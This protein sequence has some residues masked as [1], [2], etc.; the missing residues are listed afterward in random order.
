MN[1]TK[2]LC[3]FYVDDL[4]FGIDVLNVQEVINQQEM[5]RV[6]L[7]SDVVTGLINL[8]G[9]IVTAIDL[10]RRLGLGKLESEESPMN[11]VINT[12]G[13]I[14]SL[15]ADRIGD[16]IEPDIETYELPP[17]TL[18]SAIRE[19]VSGIYKLDDKLLLVLDTEEAIKLKQSH[20]FLHK[21]SV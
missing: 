7:A 16:V 5:T 17:A 20:S 10:R 9:Q 1:E 11:I 4:L 6:P 21:Q 3:T 2:L 18:S 13:G 12:N 15:V 19:M 14:L 8:R